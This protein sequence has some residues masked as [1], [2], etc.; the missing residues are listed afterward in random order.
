MKEMFGENQILNLL[1]KV[2]W[3]SYLKINLR[4]KEEELIV[5]FGRK[6]IGGD[7]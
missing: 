3:K 7:G 2:N 6:K 4:V 1:A 5:L